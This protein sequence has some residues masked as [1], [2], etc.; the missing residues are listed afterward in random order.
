MCSP[1]V[2]NCVL[3]AAGV[4]LISTLQAVQWLINSRDG[5]FIKGGVFEGDPSRG[6]SWA[7]SSFPRKPKGCECGSAVGPGS[8]Q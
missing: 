5:V 2:A 8:G 6:G 3:S 1:K 7:G 4:V